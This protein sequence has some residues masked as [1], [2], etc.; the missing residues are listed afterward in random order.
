MIFKHRIYPLGFEN[1]ADEVSKKLRLPVICSQAI[2]D[3]IIDK[4]IR[5]H[6]KRVNSKIIH[7]F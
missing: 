1:L 3:G 7:K 5:F 2:P 6:Q 4:F